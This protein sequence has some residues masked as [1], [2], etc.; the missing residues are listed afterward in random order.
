MV[1]NINCFVPCEPRLS[2]GYKYE[3]KL[4]KMVSLMEYFDVIEFFEVYPSLNNHIFL[5]VQ[6][7]RESEVI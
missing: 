1:L 2:S 7:I 3:R 5:Y 4:F 6:M